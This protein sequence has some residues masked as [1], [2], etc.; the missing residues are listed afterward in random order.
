LIFIFFDLVFVS[1]VNRAGIPIRRFGKESYADVEK[2]LAEEIKNPHPAP[3]A[4]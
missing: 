4:Q 1:V 2:Y 3:A